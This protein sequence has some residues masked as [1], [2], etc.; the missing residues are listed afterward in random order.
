MVW[1]ASSRGRAGVL[2]TITTPWAALLL[3]LACLPG[4]ASAQWTSNKGYQLLQR[5]DDVLFGV[6]TISL[7][8]LD[9]Q[10]V[11]G[12]LVRVNVLQP[13][14]VRGKTEFV[15]E[16]SRPLRFALVPAAVNVRSRAVPIAQ[17]EFVEAKILDGSWFAAEFACDATRQP[18]RASRIARDLYER[19]GPADTQ[20]I[21]CELQP[22]GKAEPRPAVEVRY[23]EEFSAVA[24]NRQWLSSGIVS[25]D[26]VHFGTVGT[27][28]ID[29]RQMNV[30]KNL[31]SGEMVFSGTCDRRAPVVGR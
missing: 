22:D 11:A 8:V 25:A 12:T 18:G 30:R 26:E 15:A 9:R 1:C 3:A 6:D 27:W 21:Y 20:I 16:C 19:G 10:H 28:H 17:L 31:A 4:V 29:R 7:A 23:S 13:N 5:V 2:G 24:V 14:P